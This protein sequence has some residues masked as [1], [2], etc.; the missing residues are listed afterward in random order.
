MRWT[1]VRRPFWFAPVCRPQRSQC[2]VRRKVLG[3]HVRGDP[4]EAHP[5][6]MLFCRV[7]S[8]VFTRSSGWNSRVEQVPLREP[9][10]KALSAGW[11]WRRSRVGLGLG[12]QTICARYP[13]AGGGCVCS[14]GYT[15]ED[16]IRGQEAV[17]SHG[18]KAMSNYS[19]WMCSTCQ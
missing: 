1:A 19:L 2:A 11:A 15:V 8:R 12:P 7:C 14:T 17:N 18:K 6:S 10:M 3:P 9:H 5:G 16:N 4:E 13:Q